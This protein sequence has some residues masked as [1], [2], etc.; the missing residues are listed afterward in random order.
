M[1]PYQSSSYPHAISISIA[2]TNSSN[3]THG[4]LL[5]LL[6]AISRLS[7]SISH[8]SRRSANFSRFAGTSTA[9]LAATGYQE[10]SPFHSVA[11]D[12]SYPLRPLSRNRLSNTGTQARSSDGGYITPGRSKKS[13]LSDGEP[14]D[15]G[16]DRTGAGDDLE[17]QDAL[18]LGNAGVEGAWPYEHRQP[19]ETVEEDWQQRTSVSRVDHISNV[20][21]VIDLQ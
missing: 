13:R 14:S 5:T 1:P 20:F 17:E 9:P 6:Y 4:S 11:D 10:T 19:L 18:L 16:Y 7:C 15:H 3:K 8:M 21:S 12:Q 2:T